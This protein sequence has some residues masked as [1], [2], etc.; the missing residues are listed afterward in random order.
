MRPVPACVLAA[1]LM[2]AAPNTMPGLESAIVLRPEGAAHSKSDNSRDD[3]L[4]KWLRSYLGDEMPGDNTRFISA[5]VNL[6]GGAEHQVIVYLTGD[7]WCG[8]GGCTMLVLA[9]QGSSYRLVTKV[10]ITR[11]P[12]RVL[13]TETH[14]WHDLSVVVAGGGI[15]NRYEA[16]LSFNGKSYPSNPT[17]RPAQPLR[18]KV[19]G[20][21]VI[22]GTEDGTHL[23]DK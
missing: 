23:Y 19:A 12:I 16:K 11:P 9:P 8:S 20:G 22:S 21:V 14:G 3:T 5:S 7:D 1:S 6:D 4:K 18:Q 15:I 2:V 10:T 13:T 17:V